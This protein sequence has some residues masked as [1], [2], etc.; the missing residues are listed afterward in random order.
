VRLVHRNVVALA[1]A[2]ALLAAA[3]APRAGAAAAPQ[4][5][6]SYDLVALRLSAPLHEL[7]KESE[8]DDRSSVS[9][10]VEYAGASGHVTLEH[11]RVSVRGHT[12]RADSECTFPKL[13]L[14]LTSS[15]TAGTMFDGVRTLKVGT[16]CGESRD[17][18]LSPKYGRLANERSAHREAFVY[19]LLD[20]MGVPTLK[21][22]PA[23]IVYQ[24]TSKVD[25]ARANAAST[26][27]STTTARGPVERDAM[28]LEDTSDAVA[29]LGGVRAI[30]PDSFTNARDT[31][32]AAD[33]ATVAFAEAMIGNFDWCL[34]FFAGDT[35][36]CDAT[37]PLW[38]MAGVVRAEGS[39]LPVIY[40]F[41]LA[42]MVTGRHLW[43]GDVYAG[44]FGA[45][46]TPA[47]LE[48]LG[49]V[50]RTRSLFARADLD[51]ERAR[52]L[53]RKDAAYAALAKSS[54]DTA[55]RQL[56]EAYLHAFFAAI[57]DDMFYGPAVVGKGEKVY[58]DARATKL[59][60]AAR[61][62]APL[63]TAVS[64]VERGSRHE[65]GRSLVKVLMLDTQWH[66]APPVKCPAVRGP[67]W[68]ARDAIGTNFPR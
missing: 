20:V 21:A 34:K 1:G 43:F 44:T 52:L 8:K 10:T 61:P 55:G 31:F 41:D 35:Y 33:T 67:V 5:F 32:T 38:N 2:A 27:S 40:D 63:G 39:P 68:I 65:G 26:S 4:L 59:A 42:G 11:V 45:A 60:C 6:S 22:R 56:I 49:Q 54:V 50:Q 37:H 19:Q 12:S 28:L 46:G 23:R 18:D 9:G 15:S 29:R 57:A 66:W 58:L 30:D 7:F 25:D 3:A 14:D 62:R 36:R 17:G 24:D 53:G 47:Q 51:T 13:K 64:I 16:H 48:V